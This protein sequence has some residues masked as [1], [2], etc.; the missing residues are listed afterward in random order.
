LFVKVKKRRLEHERERQERDEEESLIQRQKEAAQ[1]KEWGAQED[2]FHLEQ[3]ALRSKI[4]IKDGRG[5]F[6][7]QFINFSPFPISASS[8]HF[9]I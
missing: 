9:I 3:A 7:L 2:I 5:I 8:D 6:Y 4:R 1:F